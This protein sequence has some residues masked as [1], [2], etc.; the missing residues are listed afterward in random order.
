MITIGDLALDRPLLLAPMEDVSDLPFRLMCRR[1]GADVVYTE[2]ISSEGLVRDARVCLE[3][4]RLADGE[5]PVGIQIYGAQVDVMVRAAQLA[6]QAGP[7]LIDISR[8][9]RYE[10]IPEWV[11]N[12]MDVYPGTTMVDTNLTQAEID[13][14]RAFLWKVSMGAVE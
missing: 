6:E 3:K 11:A 10:W 12:P 2:F 5:H 4:L 13:V 14:V 9:L 8:R 7:D 1:L